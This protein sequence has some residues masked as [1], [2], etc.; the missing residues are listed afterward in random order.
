[1]TYGGWVTQSGADT[2][3]SGLN[4]ITRMHMEHHACVCMQGTAEAF[5]PVSACV[6]R[7][8]GTLDLSNLVWPFHALAAAGNSPKV[9]CA[10]GSGMVEHSSRSA[11][12][13]V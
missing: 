3:P 12:W 13:L 1:M 11:G 4:C 8:V 9:L 2:D 7:S 6:A 10:F 5:A